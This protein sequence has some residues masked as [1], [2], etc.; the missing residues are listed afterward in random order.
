MIRTIWYFFA[1]SVLVVGL[2]GI[3][4]IATSPVA[5]ADHSKVIIEP[6]QGSGF[7]GCQD[8]GGCYNPMVATVDVGGKVIFQNTDTVA[9]TFTAGTIED[10]A[11]GEFDSGLAIVGSS[12]EY[13][14]DTVGEIPHFCLVHPWM[15]GLIIVGDNS[16]PIKLRGV[17]FDDVN[18]NGVQDDGESYSLDIPVI[19][20]DVP[21]YF[22]VQMVK[23]DKLGIYEFE[24]ITAG[25]YIVQIVGTSIYTYVDVN[26]GTS[27]DLPNNPNSPI[28]DTIYDIIPES[29]TGIS[30]KVYSDLNGNDMLD[31]GER[32]ISAR[33]VIVINLADQTDNKR[34]STNA[35]GDYS[36]DLEAGSYLVQVVNTNTFAYVTIPD[37]AYI[38]QH[39]GL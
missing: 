13:T 19:A 17:I 34:V 39:L 24:D 27:Q 7:V 25:E 31:S 26:G 20:V 30:G 10:G 36:F 9:H 33:S 2:V 18:E 22:D 8:E 11:S 3:S 5:F 37:G 28:P 32:G 14:A 38:T 16:N 12:Y 15:T 4:Q 6:V 29:I 35:N 1:L 23:T 21:N